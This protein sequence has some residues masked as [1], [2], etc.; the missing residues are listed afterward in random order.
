MFLYD[1]CFEF[2]PGQMLAVFSGDSEVIAIG[3]NGSITSGSVLFYGHFPDLSGLFPGNRI[4]REEFGTDDRENRVV[5]CAAGIY[6]FK[7]RFAVFLADFPGNRAAYL[8]DRS[9]IYRNFLKREQTI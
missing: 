2:L 7:I 4:C 5:F 9:R 1:L 6:F 3:T 8:C